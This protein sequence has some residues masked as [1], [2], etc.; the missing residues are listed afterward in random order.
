MALWRSPRILDLVCGGY[1][2]AVFVG[3]WIQA[4]TLTRPWFDPEL[5]RW[6]Y[7][8]YL[9]AGAVVLSTLFAASL[10][11]WA[12][13]P[14]RSG[15]EAFRGPVSTDGG[16]RAEPYMKPILFVPRLPADDEAVEGEIDDVL[17]RISEIA[18]EAPENAMI[19]VKKRPVIVGRRALGP[20]LSWRVRTRRRSCSEPK[21]P[22]PQ[23]SR[24]S[25]AR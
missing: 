5:S 18:S 15:R 13:G 4:S 16:R 1:F 17:D 14:A 21:H 10:V 2:G 3:A 19:V 23:R 20:S 8:A 22:D 24:E 25:E 12:V 9:L 11:F 6:L 7:T